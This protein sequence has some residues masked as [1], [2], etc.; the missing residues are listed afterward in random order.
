MYQP[1]P[2]GGANPV[3]P[4][5]R[6]P[7]PPSV[8]NAVKLMYAGAGLSALGLILE[9]VSLSG[10]KSALQKA[11]P[12]LTTAQIHSLEVATVAIFTVVGLIGIGLWIWMALASKA[13]QN[14][15]RIVSSIL[16]GLDTIFLLLGISRTGFQLGSIVS[17]LVW[18]CGL[19]AIVL[20]WRRESSAYFQPGVVR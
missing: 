11:S 14:Y 19:G 7:A 20:V 12:D 13:G 9:F 5:E 4:V 18:L 1:Y 3:G 15:A 10:L 17:V 6:P 16:F 2:A 8:L